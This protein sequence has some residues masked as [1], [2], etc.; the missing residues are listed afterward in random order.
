MKQIFVK[1]SFLIFIF[2]ASIAVRA[3]GQAFD[4]VGIKPGMSY[5]EVREAVKKHDPSMLTRY[6]DTKWVSNITRQ[7]TT[8]ATMTFKKC[9]AKN[10]NGLGCDEE[11]QVTFGQTKKVA[12]SIT[13]ESRNVTARRDELVSAFQA[14]YKINGTPLYKNNGAGVNF[15]VDA[16]GDV[17]TDGPSCSVN[18]EGNMPTSTSSACAPQI[19]HIFMMGNRDVVTD[20]TITLT[21]HKL[22]FESLQLDA[23]RDKSEAEDARRKQIG[24]ATTQK[25]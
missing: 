12:Y 14:K 23:E 15:T 22:F 8:I 3:E 17:K 21:N 16:K 11:I 18:M 1:F 25:L 6:S 4:I 5:D 2:G 10:S 13:R 20:Y 19:G 7:P 24:K 9:S